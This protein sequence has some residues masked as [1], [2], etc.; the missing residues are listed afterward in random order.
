MCDTEPA[1]MK[2]S[3]AE[4]SQAFVISQVNKQFI[5]IKTGLTPHSDKSQ[6]VLVDQ[7]AA[8][9]RIRVEKMISEYC[10][11]VSQ[12]LEDHSNNDEDLCCKLE[13]PMKF[14]VYDSEAIGLQ[15]YKEQFKAWGISYRVITDQLDKSL[16]PDDDPE[17][18]GNLVVT[19]IPNIISNR[20]ISD[21]KL[22]RQLLLRHLHDL[23]ADNIPKLL[24]ISDDSERKLRTR[25]S[26]A[27]SIAICLPKMLLE[28]LNSRACRGMFFHFHIY[29]KKKIN[30]V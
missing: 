23:M 21:P 15:T 20:C 29:I 26:T 27:T 17:E 8:D 4:L 6:L 10:H 7:H 13:R 5:M 9:E 12:R 14:T 19:Q 24:L 30:I 3:K 1:S 25:V 11:F 2:I 22:V 28:M 18:G 16:M